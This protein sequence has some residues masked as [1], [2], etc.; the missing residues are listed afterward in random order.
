MTTPPIPIVF[1]PGLSMDDPDLVVTFIPLIPDAVWECD[2]P[3]H[4]RN[5]PYAHFVCLI[6]MKDSHDIA[7]GKHSRQC[8]VTSVVRTA[9]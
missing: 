5:V 2:A 1:P 3:R 6:T 8:P 9:R 7:G 4:G